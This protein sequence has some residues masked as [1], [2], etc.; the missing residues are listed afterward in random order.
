MREQ[1][2]NS[3]R[4]ARRRLIWVALLAL[5]VQVMAMS[6]PR[7]L[8]ASV[9]LTPRVDSGG[10]IV[11]DESYVLFGQFDHRLMAFDGNKEASA[12][13]I[14]WRVMELG[15][16]EGKSGAILLSHYL[17]D[18]IVYLQ[19]GKY[20]S[21][22]YLRNSDSKPVHTWEGSDVQA[23]LN[24][25]EASVSVVTRKE[26]ATA[27][28]GFLHPDYFSLSERSL[29]LSYPYGTH[30]EN[31]EVSPESGKKVVVPSSTY[32]KVGNDDYGKYEIGAWFVSLDT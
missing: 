16:S 24:S 7:H 1:I 20:D 10:S 26:G 2:Y 14:L 19:D 6:A 23:W 27:I 4:G 25:S 29:L 3:V 22:T 28:R 11:G 30:G 15:T 17:L 32:E 12:T 13:P 5:L 9:T 8:E 18:T 31:G 21:G